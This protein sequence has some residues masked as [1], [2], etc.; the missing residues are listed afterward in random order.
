MKPRLNFILSI[1]LF[2]FVFLIMGCKAEAEPQSLDGELR[3]L[4]EDSRI[5][6]TSLAPGPPASEAKIALGEALF[7]DKEL[8]GNRDTSCATCHHP[9]MHTSDG[10]SL[11]IGVGGHGLGATR[12]M[13]PDRE[14]IPRN[15]PDVFNR[16]DPA[17][18]TMFWDG[19][20]SGSPEMGFSNPAGMM[21]PHGLENILAAQAM[22]PVTSLDEMRGKP[23]DEDKFDNELADLPKD[24]PTVVWD[25][26]MKRLLAIPE[27][28]AMF[29][30]A[31][32]HETKKDLGFQHAANAIAAYEATTWT[33]TDSPWDQYLA[34]DNSAIS[35]GAKRGGICSMIKPSVGFVT[36]PIC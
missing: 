7:F 29:R 10:L 4:L 35:D 36:A 18:V 17:W 5:T 1:L 20:I 9:L 12:V 13:G 8:S 16:G 23:G 34:G 15:S 31:Y 3:R 2:T 28:V 11:P 33:M 24:D 21:L 32:P 25:A 26:L 6:Y 22:F 19:R 30:A 27:Y 14:F